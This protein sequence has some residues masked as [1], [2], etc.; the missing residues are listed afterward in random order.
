VPPTDA[1]R[2]TMIRP[3]V[4]LDASE[5][6][7][8]RLGFTRASAHDGFRILAHAQDAHLHLTTAVDGW[9]LT[10][11]NPFGLCLSTS[12]VD[13]VA[14]GFVGQTIERDRPEMKAWVSHACLAME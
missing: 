5:A 4:D 3:C 11:R 7:Y 12:A 10:G 8:A 13:E 6:F 14:T 2:P 9:L 1:I